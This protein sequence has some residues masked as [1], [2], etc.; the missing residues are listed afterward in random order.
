MNSDESLANSR[1]ANAK[2]KFLL[3]MTDLP[4]H[5]HKVRQ[6]ECLVQI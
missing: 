4:D 3:K 5:V 2:M 1:R 6:E